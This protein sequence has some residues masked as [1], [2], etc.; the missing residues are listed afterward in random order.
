MPFF[1]S[2]NATVILREILA[3]SAAKPLMLYRYTAQKPHEAPQDQSTL[4]LA[5]GNVAFPLIFCISR[6]LPTDFHIY[7]NSTSQQRNY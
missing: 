6:K 2:R 1:R 3:V 4:A 5:L 7:S